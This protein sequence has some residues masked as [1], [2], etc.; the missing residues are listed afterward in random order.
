MKLFDLKAALVGTDHK[1]HWHTIGTVFAG[2]DGSLLAVE[3]GNFTAEG[4]PVVKNAGFV[5]DYPQVQGIIVPRPKKVTKPDEL[6]K[7][8]PTEAGD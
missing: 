3:T 8:S 1:T 6:E 7:A 5:I 4:K 2:D